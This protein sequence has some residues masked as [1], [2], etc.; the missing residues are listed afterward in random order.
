MIARLELG[1]V[2][3][4]DVD[5]SV[6]DR[7]LIIAAT[8]VETAGEHKKTHR[9]RKEIKLPCVIRTNEVQAAFNDGVLEVCLPKCPTQRGQI[10]KVI[11]K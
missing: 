1:N 5:V 8:T 11:K 7:R 6:L 10:I 3:P 9:F 4:D 2:D